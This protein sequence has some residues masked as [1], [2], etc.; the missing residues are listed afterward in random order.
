MQEG[1]VKWLLGSG[2]CRQDV[3]VTD[4]YTQPNPHYPV[5]SLFL[6][7]NTTQVHDSVKI[8]SF[9]SEHITVAYSNNK[10]I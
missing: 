4:T 5:S 1:T 9:I 2:R 10:I 6:M 3:L 7:W 8:Y